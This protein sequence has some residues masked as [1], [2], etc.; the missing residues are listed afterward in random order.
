MAN[1]MPFFVASNVT[2]QA[3]LLEPLAIMTSPFVGFENLLAEPEFLSGMWLTLVAGL[4][5][6]AAVPWLL[7]ALFLKP[8]AAVPEAVQGGTR[9]AC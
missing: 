7:A 5:F 6:S 2:H 8:A 9:E 4:L 3:F 1:L